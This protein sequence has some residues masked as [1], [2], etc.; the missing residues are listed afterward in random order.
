MASGYKYFGRV[1]WYEDGAEF[2]VANQRPDGSWGTDVIPDTCFALLFLVHGR[3]PL[4]F[5][6]LEYD[7]EPRPP[8][9]EPS[10]QPT[11][12]PRRI[13]G[14][15]NWNQRPRDV[16]NFVRWLG[17]MN[18]RLLNWQI[19]N[20][21]IDVDDLHDAPVLYIAGNQPLNFSDE[22]IAKLR[23][24]VEQGGLILGNADC[25]SKEFAD[26]FKALGAKL[27]ARYE[28]RELPADHVIYTDQQFRR[29]AWKNPPVVLGLSNGSRELMLLIPEADPARAWQMQ[30]YGGQEELHDVAANVFLYAI[31]RRDLRF[32]GQTYIVRRNEGVGG[33]VVKVARLEYAGNWDPEPGGWR[34]LAAILHNQW[35]VDIEVE[36]V[37]LG[38]GK[39]GKEHRLAHLTGT[40][41]FVLN[42]CCP[43]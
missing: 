26:S 43:R 2:L 40:A 36:T 32:K 3:A 39:L 10:T 27:F 19:V 25:G 37:K 30:R 38:E 18:E 5:N 33:H 22:Q 1:N 23:Q 20:L 34:R 24:Y 17:R 13:V 31:D 12:Q 42:H 4:V 35:D 41:R 16:A 15:G 29:Q 9:T 6:K 28:F 7:R 14:T 8:A 11:T 21:H